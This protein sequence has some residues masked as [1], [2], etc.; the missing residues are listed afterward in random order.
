M[1]YPYRTG[2]NYPSGQPSADYYQYRLGAQNNGF[3]SQ[4]TGINSIQYNPPSS[5]TYP[6]NTAAYN[7][8]IV[9]LDDP[10][11]RVYVPVINPNSPNYQS[12]F[13]GNLQAQQ[14][15][16]GTFREKQRLA[17]NLKSFGQFRKK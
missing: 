8:N 16:R 6:T 13:N 9:A 12:V 5:S 14:N 10:R 2:V 15:F 1:Y 4:N 7:P 3:G 17:K 11:R